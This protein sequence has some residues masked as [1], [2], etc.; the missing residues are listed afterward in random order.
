[1]NEHCAGAPRVPPELADSLGW[2]LARAG[3]HVGTALAAALA[4]AG[5]TPRELSVL[6]AAAPV[7]RP[8]LGSRSW[9]A[10]TRRRW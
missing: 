8:Q 3:H 10:W 4:E 7:P 1:V 6:A 9:W 2:L 5:T